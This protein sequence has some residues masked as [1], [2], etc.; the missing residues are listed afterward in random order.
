M[1]LPVS[2]AVSKAQ[3][4][5]HFLRICKEKKRT[6]C[7]RTAENQ[8]IAY[9]TGSGVGQT[10]KYKSALNVKNGFMETRI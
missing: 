8:R 6:Y 3:C 5:V 2:Q 7:T 4:I 1:D 10:Q 9:G